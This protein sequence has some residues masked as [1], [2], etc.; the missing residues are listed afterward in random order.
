MERYL[1]MVDGYNNNNKYYHMK[2]LD[3]TCWEAEYGR[4]GKTPQH[5]TY[6]MSEWEI[7]YDEKLRKGY[8]DMTQYS[9]TSAKGNTGNELIDRLVSYSRKFVSRNY[10]G[11]VTDEQVRDAQAIVNDLKNY[12]SVWEFNN[13]LEYLFEVLP[14]ATGKVWDLLAKVPADFVPIIEREQSMLDSLMKRAPKTVNVGTLEELGLKVEKAPKDEYDAVLRHI[15][16]R[17]KG[18][19]VNVYKVENEKTEKRFN[20]FCEK[21]GYEDKDIHLWY[22]GSKNENWFGILSEGN[23]LNPNAQI[24]GRMF[25]NGI[26]T[27]PGTNGKYELQKSLGYTSLCDAYWTHESS[28][29]GFIG[30]YRVAM[31]NPKDIYSWNSE[32]GSATQKTMDKWGCDGVYAHAGD[33]FLR[34]DEAIVYREE[35][36]SIRYLIELK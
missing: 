18:R 22:H 34:N 23:K 3:G 35:Q 25:G 8:R 31:K 24:T 33:G 11:E 5:H 30:V 17:N 36:L 16:N 21:N 1:V 26:Y 20:E 15:E 12:T 2:Q 4:I 7:K 29:R 28:D 27:A 6:Y 19:V 32:V 14:R 10:A 9:E 13:R